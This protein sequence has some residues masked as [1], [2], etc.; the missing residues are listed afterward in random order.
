M[1]PAA[2]RLLVVEDDQSLR[3]GLRRVLERAGYTVESA[4]RGIDALRV[5]RE[6][7]PDL[8]I[9]DLMLPGLDGSYVLEQARREGFTAPVIVVSARSSIEQKVQSLAAGADDYVTK[10]FDLEELIARIAAQLRRRHGRGVR[11]L[12]DVVIDLDAREASRAGTTVH[13]TP[14]EFD[15]LEYMLENPGVALPRGQILEAVWGAGYKGTRR[16][17]DN[18]VRAL[19]LK[20]ESDPEQP[21]FLRTV[22]ARGYRLDL[23][24]DG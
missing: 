19:R 17:V 18:F 11:R 9:L 21:L 1:S 12:G 23:R 24:G 6:S 5:I 3:E 7:P 13:L 22:R 16:T 14:K 20:L 4:V 10:P 15:L 2:E 8:V